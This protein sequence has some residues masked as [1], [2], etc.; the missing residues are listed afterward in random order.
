MITHS[1]KTVSQDA[2]PKLNWEKRRAREADHKR[3][4]SLEADV[5]QQ[6]AEERRAESE[7]R[8]KRQEQKKANEQ[9]SEKVQVVSSISTKWTV[10][11]TPVNKILT[12]RILVFGFFFSL[13]FLTV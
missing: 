8:R 7:R 10:I 4:K 3:M 1:I 5:K 6:A 9:R 12:L 2:N 13:F 11:D